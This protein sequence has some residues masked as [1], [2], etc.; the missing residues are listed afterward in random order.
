MSDQHYS[1]PCGCKFKIVGPSPFKDDPMPLLDM[2]IENPPPCPLVWDILGKGL[3]AGVFQI[4]SSFAK[5]VTRRLKPKS[6]A[7]LN[8]LVAILRPGASDSTDENGVSYTEVY[9]NRA[10]GEAAPTHHP[11]VD[12]ILSNTLGVFSFQEQIMKIAGVVAGF[13]AGQRNNLRKCV[14]G[15]TRFVSRSRGWISIDELLVTGYHED[16]FLVM[17]E[18]GVPQWKKIE[19]IW[20]T[21]KQATHAVTV[22]SGLSV[23]ATKYHQ[24]L[25]DS[26][27]KARMRLRPD[28]DHLVVARKTEFEGRDIIPYA[29]CM[30]IAGLVTER[31]FVEGRSGKFTAFDPE[32]MEIFCSNYESAFGERPSLDKFGRVALV[33]AFAR[34][35]LLEHLEY[36]L[37]ATKKLPTVMLGATLE[38]MR[39]F[40]SFM[41]AAE[42]GVTVGGGQF[43]FSSKSIEMINQVQLMLLRFGI[44][45]LR[46]KHWAKGYPDPYYKLYVNDKRSQVIL[47]AELTGKWPKEKRDRLESVIKKKADKNFSADTFPTTVTKRFMNQYPFTGRYESGTAFTAP[48]TRARFSR[49]TDQS[50]DPYWNSVADGCSAYEYVKAI[51]KDNN[52]VE[53]FDF[54][55]AGGDTP[56]IVANGMVIHNS[57]GKKDQQLLTAVGQEFLAGAEKAG[58]VPQDLAVKL[59]DIIKHSG[60]YLFNESH[61]LSYALTTYSTAYIKAH[62]PLMYYTSWLG[63]ARKKNVKWHEE[64]A[65]LVMEAKLFD[66]EVK[67]PSFASLEAHSWTN[68]REITLGLTEAKGVG[69][70]RFDAALKRIKAAE[71]LMGPVPGWSWSKLVVQPGLFNKGDMETLIKVGAFMEPKI[72]RRRKLA[73]NDIVRD[74]TKTEQKLLLEAATKQNFPPLVDLLESVCTTSRQGGICNDEDEVKDLE[75]KIRM[76]RNPPAPLTDNPHFVS[77]WEKSAFGIPLTCMK[78][79]ACNLEHVVHSVKDLITGY[80]GTA[81]IGVEVQRVKEVKTKK[82]KSAGSLMCFASVMDHTG[83]ID[84][85]V[86]SEEYAQFQNLLRVGNN[87][88]V[89]CKRDQDKDGAIVERISQLT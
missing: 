55:V 41:L 35:R 4:E 15:D 9:I 86:F 28:E 6:L 8:A 66:L 20:S 85:V 67:P 72:P 58:V 78:L 38:T 37:S 68:G 25:T 1:M 48:L 59:W 39:D 10:N 46:Y 51:E 77:S 69:V 11:I 50:G 14:T 81:S 65:K 62:F 54:T 21:G 60:R 73:E 22:G 24:F 74:L 89:R 70:A 45:S 12:E 63:H 27:W 2:D 16:E 18:T 13:N 26:G 19:K 87:V 17:D 7:H 34:D 75:G 82:G 49:F 71:V 79:D 3:T 88:L 76:L 57:I 80:A 31:H 61:S 32:M 83:E 84:L 23:S 29:E 52:S 33:K 40:L 47:L 53:T 5:G 56:Y 42:G 43:E 36:G 44:R 64:T 30:V